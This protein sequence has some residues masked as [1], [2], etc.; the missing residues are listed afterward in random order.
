MSHKTQKKESCEVSQE[1]EQEQAR[2]LL[3]LVTD[4][5]NALEKEKRL[6]ARDPQRAAGSLAR[7]QSRREGAP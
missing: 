3:E 7:P 5:Y 2:T 1:G 4:M 6:L